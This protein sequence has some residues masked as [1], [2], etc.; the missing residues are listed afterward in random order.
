MPN[1]AQRAAAKRYYE[2]NRE[3]LV[4]KMRTRAR[5]TAANKDK[6]E[7]RTVW[8]DNYYRTSLT[9]KERLLRDW[10]SSKPGVVRSFLRDYIYPNRENLS[11][12]FFKMLESA[13]ADNLEENH[14]A[15]EVDGRSQTQEGEN[16]EEEEGLVGIQDN[17]SDYG[18]SDKGVV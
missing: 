12:A 15:Q 14:P 16:R 1:D 11:P 5:T 9:K 10:M 13:I 3:L 6:D 2:K 8:M 17:T 4:E 18:G 7:R